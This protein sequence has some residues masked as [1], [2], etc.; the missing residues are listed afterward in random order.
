MSELE[1]E[2]I[3]A[4]IL[5]IAGVSVNIITDIMREALKDTSLWDNR[6]SF[7]IGGLIG[8][9]LILFVC[10]LWFIRLKIKQRK[11]GG[12]IVSEENGY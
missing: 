9:G 8:G 11:R 7:I 4:I 1:L 6:L 3:A 5:S 10:I 2:E 12:F